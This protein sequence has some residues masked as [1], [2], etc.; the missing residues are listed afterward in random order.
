MSTNNATA[1]FITNP[2][3]PSSGRRIVRIAAG[4]SVNEL[5]AGVGN[6]ALMPFIVIYNSAPLLRADWH[7]LI[8]ADS[9]VVLCRLIGRD[10]LD[11]ALGIIDPIH[12]ELTDAIHELGDD[13]KDLFSP[14]EAPSTQKQSQLSRG[15]PTYSLEAQGNAVRTGQAIPIIYGRFRVYPDYIIYPYID[16]TDNNQYI[17]AVYGVALG[18]YELSDYRIGDTDLSQLNEI[19]LESLPDNAEPTILRHNIR[20]SQDVDG[21]DFDGETA[22]EGQ[23]E[24]AS[25]WL[26][27]FAANEKHYGISAVE[28]DIVAPRGIYTQDSAGNRQP[29]SV[30]LHAQIRFVDGDDVVEDWRSVGGDRDDIGSYTEITLD[31][32]TTLRPNDAHI[33][34][35][36]DAVRVSQTLNFSLPATL[37]SFAYIVQIRVR[38]AKVES[39][40]SR[41]IERVSWERMKTVVSERVYND[42]GSFQTRTPAIFNTGLNINAFAVRMRV[43]NN[44]SNLASRKLSVLAQRKLPIYEPD[45]RQWTEPQ[46]TRNPA[47][48]VVD[49]LRSTYG[50]GFADSKINLAAFA[51]L[52]AIYDER[53]DYFDATYDRQI[54][55]SEALRLVSRN[56]RGAIIGNNGIFRLVRDSAQSI[57]AM[58]FS[59]ANIVKNSFRLAYKMATDDEYGGID[60]EFLDAE[61]NYIPQNIKR[62][63]GKLQSV[64]FYGCTDRAMATREADYLYAN[65]KYRRRTVTFTT[66]LEGHSVSYGDLIVI[67]HDMPKWGKSGFVVGA[68]LGVGRKYIKLLLGEHTADELAAEAAQTNRIVFRKVDGG[69][70]PIYDLQFIAETRGGYNFYLRVDDHIGTITDDKITASALATDGTYQSLDLDWGETRTQ[71]ILLPNDADT[72]SVNGVVKSVKPKGKGQV[73]ITAVV[74]D[75]RV[76]IGT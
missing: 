71:Y 30:T 21:L 40:D 55:V 75:N 19:R 76:H 3:V 10:E 1:I 18:D 20:T 17:N 33:Y 45:T 41:T 4:Q 63:E 39:E 22:V 49:I 14:P 42:G 25:D 53:G 11:G 12:E 43:T 64:K 29:H 57:P 62:G 16:Y 32:N 9:I 35:S 59:P 36:A 24:P 28:L 2:L 38:R 60:L 58:M 48:A 68:E 46:V 52:A 50:A 56:G 37:G 73:E 26:G 23:D 34:G 54:T 31:G 7:T 51:R 13:I 74:E 61:Q 15:S 6:F 67:A 65:M 66:E 70:S 5:V 44:I 72:Y 47:W 69:S 8:T 27:P